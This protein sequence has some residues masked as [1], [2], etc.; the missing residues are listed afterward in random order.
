ME[1]GEYSMALDL[2][3]KLLIENADNEKAI[4]LRDEII[5]KKKEEEAAKE[6]ELLKVQDDLSKT[7]SNLGDTLSSTAVTQIPKEE[8]N[9]KKRSLQNLMLLERKLRGKRKRKRSVWQI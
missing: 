3:N 5:S 9:R 6:Q 8:E 4:T 1:S 2:I 7:I